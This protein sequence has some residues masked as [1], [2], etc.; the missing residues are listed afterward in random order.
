MFFIKY[1]HKI[2]KRLISPLLGNKCRFH[3]PCSDYLVEACEKHG[4]WRGIFL[5]MKRLVRCQPFSKGWF[6]PVPDTQ[7]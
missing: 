4:V 3:P 2:Y 1:I 6:D 7:K 5:S